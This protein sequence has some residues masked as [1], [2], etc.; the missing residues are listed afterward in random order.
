M[1]MSNKIIEPFL[2]RLAQYY[3]KRAYYELF[4]HRLSIPQSIF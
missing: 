2:K 1:D 4:G 3:I